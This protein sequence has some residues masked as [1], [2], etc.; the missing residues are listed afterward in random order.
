MHVSQALQRCG[1]NATLVDWAVGGTTHD[2]N[3]PLVRK[4]IR[5]QVEQADATIVA[6]DCGT[7]SRVREVPR[8]GRGTAPPCRSMQHPEDFPWLRRTGPPLA[9]RVA[10]ANSTSDFLTGTI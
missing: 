7:Y 8:R 4:A 3:Q 6:M 9:R 5:E 1:W 2:V 10:Q